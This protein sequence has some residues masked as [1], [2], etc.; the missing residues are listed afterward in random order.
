MQQIDKI[1]EAAERQRLLNLVPGYEL[2]YLL[3]R[4]GLKK[5]VIIAC[6]GE[7]GGGKSGSAAVMSI[8]DY[9]A[10]GVRCFSNMHVAADI[11]ISDET[12]QKY[13]FKHGGVARYRS[14]PL[15]LPRLLRFD[16]MFANSVILID[17]INV[18]VS[19]ARRAMS[20]T[21]LFSNRLAQELRHLQSALLMTCLSE[22]VLDSRLRDT[23]DAMVRCEETAYFPEGIRSEKEIGE[24]F[25]WTVYFLNRCFTGE[26]YQ[27]TKIANAKAI[28]HFKRWRGI[29]DDKEFQGQGMLKYG[30]N[31]KD[32]LGKDVQISNLEV[33]KSAVVSQHDEKWGWFEK[34]YLKY[35]TVGDFVLC[36][37]VW[38]DPEVVAHH[39]YKNEISHELRDIYNVRCVRIGANRVPYYNFSKMPADSAEDSDDGTD[40]DSPT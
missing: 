25:A 24:D 26:T 8:V 27:E 37:A 13:G 39:L 11:E 30:V 18:E 17:E 14:L 3:R 35:M 5:D 20:T 32:G 40:G 7:R 29:Y 9:M 10:C 36:E 19:E 16:P 34:V 38:N 12:A 15:D 6:I 2:G 4:K 22:M 23:C 28:F 1:F 33:S 31:I 21:N